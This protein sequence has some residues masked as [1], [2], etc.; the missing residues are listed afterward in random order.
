[1]LKACPE[2]HGNGPNLNLHHGIHNLIGQENRYRNKHVI[3]LV[4]ALLR[5]LNIILHG[6]NGK[7]ILLTNHFC[8]TVNI[9]SKRT[10]HTDA[11][12]ILYVGN[13]VLNGALV[14]VTL[15]FLY[16]AFRGLDSRL[17]IF[18]R[19]ILMYILEFI[20]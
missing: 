5:M 10:H 2:I 13:H 12:N 15:Q 14:S 7:V 17:N 18:N 20:A 19:I 4:S 8:Q 3:A 9:G 1:M 6:N 16:D 11:R